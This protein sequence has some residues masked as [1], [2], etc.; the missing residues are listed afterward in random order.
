[1][2]GETMWLRA[3]YHWVMIFTASDEPVAAHPRGT[4]RGERYTKESSLSFS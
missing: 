1:M 2:I 3:S 4:R